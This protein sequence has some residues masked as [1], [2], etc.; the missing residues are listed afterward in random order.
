MRLC[1]LFEVPIRHVKTLEISIVFLS[2]FHEI[3]EGD[4]ASAVAVER[5]EKLVDL[6]RRDFQE[7]F[8]DSIEGFTL[9]TTRVTVKLRILKKYKFLMKILKKK[10]NFYKNS[11][12]SNW[13]G[14]KMFGNFLFN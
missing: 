12:N 4:V 14:Q 8:E 7:H 9:E 2:R 10:F 1:F 3:F 6:F 11:G 13:L 5:V